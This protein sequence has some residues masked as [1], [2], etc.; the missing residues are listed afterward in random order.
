MRAHDETLAE[1]LDSLRL[2]L[3]RMTTPKLRLPDKIHVDLPRDL[4]T[5]FADA[6]YV[7]TVET[8]TR[9]QFLPF[10]DALAFVHQLT[11]NSEPDW[12]RYCI[13][14]LPDKSRRLDVIPT[15]PQNTYKD[16]GWQSWGDWLGTG[17]VAHKDRTFRSFKE[18]RECVVELKLNRAQEWTLY[19]K[20]QLSGKPR[21]PDDIP[22]S[23]ARTY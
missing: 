16:D 23:P 1:Q 3:G 11:I 4:P 9:R 20:G 5:E 7:R 18:A 15:N 17:S 21:K 19:C 12:R 10:E 2:N 14:E 8:T 22:F 6:F 13:G